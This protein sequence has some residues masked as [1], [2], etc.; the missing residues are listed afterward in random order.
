MKRDKTE[1]LK[2]WRLNKKRKPLIF[3]GARQVGKTYLLQEF[4]K[5]AYKQLA[6]VNFEHPNAPKGLFE[7]DFDADRIITVLNAYGNLKIN[8]EDTLI[9]FDEI[10][11]APK[12]LTALKYFFETAPEYHIIGAGAL[13]GV[14]SHQ[15][16]SLPVGEVEVM[17]LGGMSFCACVLAM[18]EM[19][20]AEHL[21]KS[22][23]EN[24]NFFHQKLI[25][26]LRYYLFV[27]GMPEAVRD[28]AEIR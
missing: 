10:Q 16:E 3:L 7:V 6:Y 23:L 22:D 12:V 26:Y 1:D 27:G 17:R 11:T 9:V 28:F 5:T 18:G 25:N 8:A 14:C 4:G 20:M 13:L 2:N 15:G 19:G 24:L 21:A